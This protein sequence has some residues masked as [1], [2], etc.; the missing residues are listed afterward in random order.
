MIYDCSGTKESL[1]THCAPSMSNGRVSWGQNSFLTNYLFFLI[2]KNKKKSR[3]NVLL[4]FLS[5][6]AD[7]D[8]DMSTLQVN[9][10]P[11]VSP[12]WPSPEVVMNN[13]S[14]VMKQHEVT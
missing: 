10:Q 5:S 6:S 8:Q 12:S 2:P 13:V 14:S 1:I 9:R 4:L 11:S 7:P 3:L